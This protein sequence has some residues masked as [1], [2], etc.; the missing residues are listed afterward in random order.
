M[1]NIFEHVTETGQRCFR[2]EDVK[3]RV[4]GFVL[5]KIKKSGETV[6]GYVLVESELEQAKLHIFMYGTKEDAVTGLYSMRKPYNPAT[7]AIRI[8]DVS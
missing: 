8:V 4:L 6:W 1:L 3:N 5:P 7:G 2:V